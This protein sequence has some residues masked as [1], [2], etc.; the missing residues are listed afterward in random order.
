MVSLSAHARPRFFEQVAIAGVGDSNKERALRLMPDSIFFIETAI[1]KLELAK[2]GLIPMIFASRVSAT[3]R[4]TEPVPQPH[5]TRAIPTAPD[6]P[7]YARPPVA[8]PAVH[9]NA[10]GRVRHSSWSQTSGQWHSLVSLRNS[11]GFI[12]QINQPIA[13]R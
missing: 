11:G 3:M 9:R 6:L 10:T 4:E 12:T 1:L 8:C 7:T 5:P 2:A 13:I